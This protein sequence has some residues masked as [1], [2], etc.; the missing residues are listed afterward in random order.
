MLR[1]TLNDVPD[2]VPDESLE[3]APPLWLTI[4]FASSNERRIS[5]GSPAC[6]RETGEVQIWVLGASGIGDRPVVDMA[7]NVRSKMRDKV[8]APSIRTTDADPP[9]HFPDDGDWFAAIVPVAYVYD[10]VA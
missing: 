3:S 2:F 10:F 4:D 8:L 1:E 6:R 9:F 5:I 7:D